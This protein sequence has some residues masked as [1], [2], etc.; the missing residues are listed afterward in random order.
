MRLQTLER[1]DLKL[2]IVETIASFHGGRVA[3]VVCLRRLHEFPP[4]TP[5]LVTTFAQTGQNLLWGPSFTG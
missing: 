3:C 2:A 5:L 1:L 4:L